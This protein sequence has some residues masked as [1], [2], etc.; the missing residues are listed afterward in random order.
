MTAEKCEEAGWQSICSRD[1]V[2]NAFTGDDFASIFM[3]LYDLADGLLI[4]Y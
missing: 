1:Q 3:V 2:W 4:R